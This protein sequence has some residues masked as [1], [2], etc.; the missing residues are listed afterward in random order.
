MTVEPLVYFSAWW[1]SAR[2]RPATANESLFYTLTGQV[3]APSV[4]AT[5]APDNSTVAAA[6]AIAAEPASPLARLIAHP[7]VRALSKDIFTGQIIATLIVLAFIAVFLL[8]EWISQNARPG[9]FEDPDLLAEELRV[10]QEERM[11]LQ[12][13]VDAMRAGGARE[14]R[15]R[16]AALLR[17]TRKKDEE[18]ARRKADEERARL[19][20]LRQEKERREEEEKIRGTAEKKAKKVSRMPCPAAEPAAC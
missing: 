2:P 9:V 4:N 14:E 17:E 20:A 12:V 5:V 11:Q 16:E 18:R 3:H 15:E 6:G 1:I 7:R 10:A 19:R 8:R 13:Q